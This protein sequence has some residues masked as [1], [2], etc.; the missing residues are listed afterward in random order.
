MSTIAA[1][2]TSTTALTNTGDTTGNLVFQTNGTTTAM[3]I[4]TSQRVGIGTSSPA[5]ALEISRAAPVIRLSS[6]AAAGSASTYAVLNATSG[7]SGNFYRTFIA[8]SDSGSTY[9]WGIGNFGTTTKDV[10]AFYSG[11]LTERMR[12]DASGNVGIGTSSP[13]QRFEASFNDTTTNRTNP[14]N[15]AAITSTSSSAGGPPFN[16]FGPALV[17]R[18]Q[19]YNGTVYNGPRI[20][21]A[22]GDD[23]INT[24]AGASLAFD[25]TATKGAAPTQAAVINPSG[26][27]FIGGTTAYGT[28]K[29][30]VINGNNVSGDFGFVTTL[31][32]NCNNTS[33]YHYIASTGGA[34]KFY[35]YG[36]GSA[37]N[38]TGSY[39]TI[40]DIKL[41]ENIVDATPKLADVMRLQVRNFNLKTEP[42][43]K[44]IGFV[45][46]EFEQ[47]F[48]GMVDES[49]DRDA[50]GNTLETTTKHIKTSVLV[51]IL[52]KA[53]QEQQAM[54]TQLQAE[55]AALKGAQ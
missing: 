36:N 9:D 6:T 43:H 51:P 47:V 27:L 20:R 5:E 31:G 29:L 42:T 50:N 22:I 39:G 16:G 55:V 35:V 2:T 53:I 14:V 34:D 12:I 48:P 32:S 8:T 10:L 37:A 11:G 44:Q 28:A 46:Q 1:G 21:M 23:S 13:T 45:A 52:V 41:K 17:F 26:C 38:A 25:V 54:I 24:T 40:S 15:V 18:S 19:S 3:T 49:P 33:S 7:A 4:D 30:V